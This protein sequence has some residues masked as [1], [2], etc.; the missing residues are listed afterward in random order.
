MTYVTTPPQEWSV[1]D[2]VQWSQVTFPF[3]PSLSLSIRK[4][5]VDGP[6]LLYHVTDKTLKDDLKVESLGQRVKVLQKIGEVKASARTN[7]F[8]TPVST[9]GPH[10]GFRFRYPDRERPDLSMS[11]FPYNVTR[12]ISSEETR[13]Y[14]LRRNS[15]GDV[16]LETVTRTPRSISSRFRA[17]RLSSGLEPSFMSPTPMATQI[18]MTPATQ[19]TRV[20]PTPSLPTPSSFPQDAP[21]SSLYTQTMDFGDDGNENGFGEPYTTWEE[22]DATEPQ[23][24]TQGSPARR[25]K[26]RKLLHYFGT[27]ELCAIDVMMPPITPSNDHKDD[28]KQNRTE[29]KSEDMFV[30]APSIALGER[31]Y[32]QH[33]MRKMQLNPDQTFFPWNGLERVVWKLHPEELVKKHQQMQALVI[34]VTSELKV[35][36][37][38]GVVD[39][40]GL[41]SALSAKRDDVSN[42]L[43]GPGDD[44]EY[45]LELLQTKW[46]NAPGDVLLPVFNESDSEDGGYDE[47]TLRDVDEG[48]N[49]PISRAISSDVVLQ[50]IEAEILRMEDYWRSKTFPHLVLKSYAVYSKHKRWNTKKLVVRNYGNELLQIDKRLEKYRQEYVEMKWRSVQEVKAHCGN[51]EESVARRC[52][53]RWLVELLLGPMPEKPVKKGKEMAEILD[54]E[55]ESRVDTDME[56]NG[57]DEGEEDGDEEGDEEG[58]DE[59]GLEDDVESSMEGFVIG[60]DEVEFSLADCGLDFGEQEVDDEVLEGD[61]PQPDE[62]VEVDETN[63]DDDQINGSVEADDI[64]EEKERVKLTSKYV[65]SPPP[66]HSL[67]HLS[68]LRDR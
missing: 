62:D 13:E 19:G 26:R 14:T 54:E 52:E 43:L 2:V 36:V 17:E 23:P 55:V 68:W 53:L 25:R 37:S 42:N 12:G 63:G 51:L 61:A 65:P 1:E 56:V 9:V 41:P 33:L 47:A 60:D 15:T 31:Q 18:P 58:E 46:Q 11:P 35:K 8:V 32:V 27:K 57:E 10:P 7:V 38:R 34:D 5:D 59:S 4:N 6:I 67:L 30:H 3:G 20:T 21:A 29:E 28:E 49:G 48:A 64:N 16:R 40:L 39:E 45:D 50:T 66:H 22:N 44:L 24:V